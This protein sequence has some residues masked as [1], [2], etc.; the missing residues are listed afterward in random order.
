VVVPSRAA[1][2]SIEVDHVSAVVLL[3]GIRDAPRLEAIKDRAVDAK[4]RM[5]RRETE[6][7]EGLKELIEDDE[8]DSLM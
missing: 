3:S 7:K 8:L 1:A 2:E 6:S 4:G 5:E